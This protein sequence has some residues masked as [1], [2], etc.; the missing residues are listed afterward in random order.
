MY[1]GCMMSSP[2]VE[3]TLQDILEDHAPQDRCPGCP[4]G[5]PKVGSKGDPKSPIVFVAESPGIEEVKQGVP[6]V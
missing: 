1:D 4:F 6:I 2:V 3:P 5:G